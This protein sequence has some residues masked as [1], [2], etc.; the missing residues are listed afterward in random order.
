MAKK[1]ASTTP[2]P[3]QPL[4][5]PTQVLFPTVFGSIVYWMVGL[6]PDVDAYLTFLLILVLCANAAVAM[7]YALSAIFRNTTAAIAAGSVV[8]M[9]MA[10]FSGLLLDI[11]NLAGWL[12]PL[13]FLSI[14]RYTYHA[15]LINEYADQPINCGFNVVCA[16]RDGNAVLAYVGAN[17]AEKALNIGMLFIFML[18]FRLV[19]FLALKYHST[20]ITSV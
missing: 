16:F 6:R 18:G 5:P 12:R 8:I 3:Y 9:P 4:P 13:Q 1:V 10:L 2:T 17:P 15:I 7:G 14:I 20:R 11:E 19:A